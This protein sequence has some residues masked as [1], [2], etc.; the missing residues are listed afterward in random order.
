MKMCFLSC[1]TRDIITTATMDLNGNKRSVCDGFWHHLS[2]VL[3]LIQLSLVHLVLLVVT[4]EEFNFAVAFIRKNVRADLV[5]EV[6][7]V[8]HAQNTPCKFQ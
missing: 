2:L 3:L 1:T 4:H 7:V 6:P 8:T 5:E